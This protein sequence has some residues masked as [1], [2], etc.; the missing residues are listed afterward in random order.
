MTVKQGRRGRKNTKI[1]DRDKTPNAWS[2]NP[3]SLT[4]RVDRSRCRLSKG[5]LRAFKHTINMVTFTRNSLTATL[6]LNAHLKWT[7]N[8]KIPRAAVRNGQVTRRLTWLGKWL[9]IWTFPPPLRYTSVRVQKRRCHAIKESYHS[10]WMAL[11]FSPERRL[12][13]KSR[14][15]ASVLPPVTGREEFV[16]TPI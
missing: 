14:G 15:D 6:K 11:I 16:F 3:Y 4:H 8:V 2:I 7:L 1:G 10:P 9:K 13:W 12:S 5:E